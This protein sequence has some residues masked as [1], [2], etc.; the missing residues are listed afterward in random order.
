MLSAGESIDFFVPRDTDG[1]TLSFEKPTPLYSKMN[2]DRYRLG[3]EICYC[4]TLGECWILRSGAN[5]DNSTVETRTCHGPS[6]TT[7]QQ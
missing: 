2:K 3:V 7:F 1:S 5:T 6:A 4:S